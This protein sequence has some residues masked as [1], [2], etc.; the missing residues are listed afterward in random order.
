MDSIHDCFLAGV[1]NCCTHKR[2][3]NGG[4]PY[5]EKIDSLASAGTVRTLSIRT[6]P[7]LEGD[8]KTP[9]YYP[10]ITI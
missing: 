10:M 6:K 5:V 9:H 2:F 3:S 1:R 8:T 7:S 4:F